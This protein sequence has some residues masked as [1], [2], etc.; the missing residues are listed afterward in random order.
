MENKCRFGI[1]MKKYLSEHDRY[2]EEHIINY[3]V[4]L[5]R[6]LDF[7][8]TKIRWLQHER[9]IH[10]IV[11]AL[12][13]LAF[14]FSCTLL[15]VFPYSVMT[16]SLSIITAVLLIAYLIHY[17]IL[18]NKV[19]YWYKVYDELYEIISQNRPEG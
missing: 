1:N 16:L 17:F 12:T 2:M 3:G 10:L 11:T 8:A 14:L 7:H 6:L 4:E 13:V 19:Q 15:M 9:L 18:E 5:D